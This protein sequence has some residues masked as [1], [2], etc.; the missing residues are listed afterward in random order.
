MSKVPM[1]DPV[2]GVAAPATAFDEA[3]AAPGR[4]EPAARPAGRPA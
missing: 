3:T 1:D 4:T 2:A